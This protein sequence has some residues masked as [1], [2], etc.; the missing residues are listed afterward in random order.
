MIIISRA[1][2]A[3]HL[4]YEACIPLMR[5][6]MVALAR[7]HTRQ[8]LRS[9]V[10]LGGGNAFGVMP[11]AMDE[12]TFGAKLVSVFP[13]NFARGAQ[14]HQGVVVVFDPRDGAPVCVLHA[15]EI[16]AIRTAAASAAAT[17]ALARPDAQALAI[18]GYGEQAWTH[19]LAMCHVRA[20]GSVAVWGRSPERAAAFARRV[21][22][23][24]GVEARAERTAGAAAAAAD[25]I[26]TTTAAVEP[27]LH[28]RDVPDG[29]HLNVV[30]S[31]RA[32]P[33]E[34]DCELV[35]RARFFADHREGVLRQGAEFLN[36]KAAGLVDDAHVLGEIGQVMDG[37]LAGRRSREDVTIYKSLGSIVQDLACGW[38]LYQVAQRDG[39]GLK[40]TF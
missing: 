22:S 19:V 26:C 25:I 10:D 9:I 37:S 6:A 8:L 33:V 11:G 23:E 28:S 35:V 4:P 40:V 39:F 2:V 16:T 38:Y 1:E 34:I 24:L 36:A 18:L 5:E 7:G 27:I 3:A 32:G 30:G 12:L 17:D 20:I 15:G 31:G 21:Q 29:A 13:G 14:S